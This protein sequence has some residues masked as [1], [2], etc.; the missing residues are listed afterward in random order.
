MQVEFAAS[1]RADGIMYAAWH[2]PKIPELEKPMPITLFRTA[3]P[4]LHLAS[5]GQQGLQNSIDPYKV[6]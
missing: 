1:R 4:S 5:D 3:V 6:L 2:H